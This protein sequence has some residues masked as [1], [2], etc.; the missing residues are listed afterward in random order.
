MRPEA[1]KIYRHFKGDYYL[2]L[3]IAKNTETNEEYVIYRKF[4]DDEETVW[5]RPMESWAAPVITEMGAEIP[6]FEEVDPL[7][8][9]GNCEK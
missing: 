4:A 3:E 2:V 7:V 9:F 8:E 6:R 1:N 5:A